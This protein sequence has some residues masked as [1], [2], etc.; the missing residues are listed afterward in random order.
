MMATAAGLALAGMI[1]FPAT[2]AVFATGRA[3]DQIRTSICN[4]NLNVKIGGAHA[5]VS[6]GPDGAT[7]QALED[8]ALMRVLPN[9]KVLVPADSMQTEAAVILRPLSEGEFGSFQVQAIDAQLIDLQMLAAAIVLPAVA[10]EDIAGFSGGLT[11]FLHRM[12]NEISGFAV[13]GD[14]LLP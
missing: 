3:W 11:E 7:H 8:V 10:P 13:F 9:M 12:V 5:G 4:M 14:V 6:V 1:P 2:Y